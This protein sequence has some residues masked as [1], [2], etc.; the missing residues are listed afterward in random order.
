MSTYSCL[1]SFMYGFKTVSCNMIN[2]I[3]LFRFTIY[4]YLFVCFSDTLVGNTMYL[5]GNTEIN[6]RYCCCYCNHIC[7]HFSNN[8]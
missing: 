6:C 7:G 2:Y 1:C 4:I 3:N 5:Y 8:N